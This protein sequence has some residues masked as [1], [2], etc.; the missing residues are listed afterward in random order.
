MHRTATFVPACAAMLLGLSAHAQTL[1]TTFTYQ[2]RL[3]AGAGGAS[4]D[5]DF[6]FR[7]FSVPTGGSSVGPLLCSDNLA[8]VDGFFTVHLDFGAVYGGT[9]LYLEVSVRA[10]TGQGCGDATGFTVL[11][12]QALTPAPYA[13]YAVSA[14]TASNANAAANASQL[15]GQPPSFYQ[16]ASNMSAGTLPSAR[17]TGTY[18]SPLTFS[19]PSNAF[20]GSGAG[21]TSLNAAAVSTGL[22]A[23]ARLSANVALLNAPQTFSA[24][25]TFSIAPIFTAAGAPFTV[26]STSL[27]TNLNADLLD[28]LSASS[29]L[30]TIPNP[31]SLTGN[32][33]GP[34][35]RAENASLNSAGAGVLGVQ[36]AA[37]GT[38][39]AV[40]GIASS[41][42]GR[43]VLGLATN[44]TGANYGG[45]FESAST[46]GHGVYGAATATTGLA[47]GGEFTTASSDGYGVHATATGTGGFNYGVWAQA[48][49][50]QGTGVYA[51]AT[52]ASG[53]NYGIVGR[54]SSSGLG[55]AIKAQADA[56]TGFTYGLWAVNASSTGR[57]VYAEATA[58]SGF[59]FGV[60]GE[61]VSPDGTGVYGRNTSTGAGSSYGGRFE[62]AGT[63]GAG[64]LGMATATSGTI[65]GVRGVSNS[66]GFG[67]FASGASGASGVKSFRID[68]PS[69]PANK[70]L[71]HYSVESPE[72]LNTYSGKVELDGHGGATITMPAY[73]ASMNRDPRYTLTPLGAAMPMLHVSQEIDET[74]LASGTKLDPG[75]AVP[76][77]TFRI[78]GGVPG[79]RVSWRVEAVRSDRWVQRHGAPVEADKQGAERGT[80]QHP[81]FYGEAADKGLGYVPPAETRRRD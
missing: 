79:A 63:N 62:A 71:L 5:H 39:P 31:L 59:S 53:T 41:V 34:V 75:S 21:L 29:F 9:A 61:A 40:Q 18:S 64:V 11:P 36:T 26:S 51:H 25:K 32:T 78:A 1:P 37:T 19:S 81:E 66:A 15:A 8:V 57:G 68:H 45:R 2:G 3:S 28:G 16:N 42:G 27:V 60:Y 65:Y 13:H 55:T 46:S 12:R 47:T 10:D 38:A 44:T 80:Y 14:G 58:T 74:L 49:G 54:T 20:T 72:V 35:I 73:F 56:A 67:V 70:Y 4:G 23:D 30:T 43:G 48:A 33:A 50:M 76:V 7:L 6:Q 69:D 17:L 77:C 22:L 52:H 24:A